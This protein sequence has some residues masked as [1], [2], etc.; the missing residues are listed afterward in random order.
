MAPPGVERHVANIYYSKI[1]ASRRREAT[2]FAL[3]HEL[4]PDVRSYGR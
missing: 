2:A 4:G 1:G 3:S